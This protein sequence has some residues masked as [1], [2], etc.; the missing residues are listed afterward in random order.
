MLQEHITSKH[1][2]KAI[3]PTCYS[4][5]TRAGRSPE[6]REVARPRDQVRKRTHM[7]DHEVHPREAPC[8]DLDT[9]HIA[10]LS[11]YLTMI[12]Y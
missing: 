1:F 5:A 8:I 10:M 12:L 2:C 6:E 3:Y 7:C 9:R 4:L 11:D